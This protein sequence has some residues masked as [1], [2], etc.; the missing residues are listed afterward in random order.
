MPSKYIPNTGQILQN[1]GSIHAQYGLNTVQILGKPVAKYKQKLKSSWNRSIWE[2]RSSYLGYPPQFF[3]SRLSNRVWGS[4]CHKIKVFKDQSGF[5]QASSRGKIWPSIRH[6]QA[7]PPGLIKFYKKSANG[8]GGVSKIM[9]R[10][11]SGFNENN[12]VSII[13]LVD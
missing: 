5:N 2:L 10:K 4:R 3:D 7:A 1:T 13:R 8:Q 9:L 12:T 11:L 6:H